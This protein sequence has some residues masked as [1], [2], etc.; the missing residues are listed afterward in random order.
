[1]YIYIYIPIYIVSA[2]A[3]VYVYVYVYVRIYTQLLLHPSSPFSAPQPYVLNR[4]SRIPAAQL[5]EHEYRIP[6]GCPCI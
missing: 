1:M 5:Q 2:C 4:Y 3:C 6:P